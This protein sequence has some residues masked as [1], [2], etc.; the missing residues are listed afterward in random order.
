MSLIRVSSGGSRSAP[1]TNNNLL[2]GSI[3]VVCTA[4]LFLPTEIEVTKPSSL[5]SYLHVSHKIQL[6]A[7]MLLGAFLCVLVRS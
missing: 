3:V 4:V 2:I 7:A 6:L 1:H 5:P